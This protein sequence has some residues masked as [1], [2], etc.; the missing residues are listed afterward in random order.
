MVETVKREH[1][2][3]YY[4]LENYLT[5][6]KELGNQTMPAKYLAID[7]SQIGGWTPFEA[8]D[9]YYSPSE[10]GR[11][12]VQR[13]VEAAAMASLST[14]GPGVRP[15]INPLGPDGKPRKGRP[16]KDWSSTRPIRTSKKKDPE[17]GTPTPTSKKASERGKRKRSE[18]E[19]DDEPLVERDVREGPSLSKV[20][21]A[22]AKKRGRPPKQKK[23]EAFLPEAPRI[24]NAPGPSSRPTVIPNNGSSNAF[25][26]VGGPVTIPK[27]AIGQITEYAGA[28][29]PGPIPITGQ[30]AG[31]WSGGLGLAVPVQRLILEAPDPTQSSHDIHASQEPSDRKRSPSQSLHAESPSKRPRIAGQPTIPSSPAPSS[32]AGPPLLEQ[33]I[34]APSIPPPRKQMWQLCHKPNLIQSF[35]QY[36]ARKM[37]VNVSY[38]RREREVLHLLNETDGIA[39]AGPDFLRRHMAL[40]TTWTAEGQDV[41]APAGTQLDK[42]TLESLLQTMK[43]RNSIKITKTAV[44]R[45]E[46]TIFYLPT[47]TEEAL[48]A[49]VKSLSASERIIARP[50]YESTAVRYQETLE[51]SRTLKEPI[52]PADEDLFNRTEVEVRAALLSD[53]KTSAQLF[54]YIVARLAR[55]RELHLFTLSQITGGDSSPSPNHSSVAPYVVQTRYFWNDIP[56]SMYCAFVPIIHHNPELEHLLS[57]DE[58]RLMRMQ[59]VPL[60]LRDILEVG[61]H[62]CKTKIAEVLQDLK[63]LGLVLPL[64]RAQS[65]VPDTSGKMADGTAFAL[66]PVQDIS[67]TPLQNIEFWQYNPTAPIYRFAQA[68]DQPP[69]LGFL[70]TATVDESMTYW[71]TAQYASQALTY[72][73]GNEITAASQ[74]RRYEG[75]DDLARAAKIN[76]SWVIGYVLSARQKAYLMQHVN[77]AG[78]GPQDGEERFERVWYAVAAPRP[79]VIAFYQMVRNQADERRARKASKAHKQLEKTRAIQAQQAIK[80]QADARKLLAQKAKDAKE[81]MLKDWND[82]VRAVHPEPLTEEEESCPALIRVR[83][84]FFAAAGTLDLERVRSGILDAL[85]TMGPSRALTKRPPAPRLLPP[86]KVLARPAVRAPLKAGKKHSKSVA[87]LIAMQDPVGKET[88]KEKRERRAANKGGMSDYGISTLQVA[89]DRCPVI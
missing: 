24:P 41:S 21:D 76:R 42:R 60:L 54:N 83:K 33:S 26:L 57:T 45:K 85:S 4:T 28:F 36:T 66:Q 19:A 9:F 87:E 8:E 48:H 23:P 78:E 84:S 20:V 63:M 55:A 10:R 80:R 59:D 1:R 82:A 88:A 2:L 71:S 15:H 61:R 51:P 53:P 68:T 69:L 89:N 79:D 40:L 39:F 46:T 58:G 47:V 65:D 81:R 16:R 38:M 18:M 70:P 7:R 5:M 13:Y 64:E 43:E 50:R 32:N 44:R 34:K 6:M 30:I 25:A 72:S 37:Q 62:R 49:F 12:E 11:K 74:T 3:K 75:G 17:A 52:V 77:Q 14:G 73:L 31:A 56:V 67:T 27:T 35:L 22:P 86:V 29:D